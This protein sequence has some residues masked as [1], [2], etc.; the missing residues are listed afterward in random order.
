MRVACPAAGISC[1]ALL[2]APAP[3]RADDAGSVHK[4]L[5]PGSPLAVTVV[6]E[7][8]KVE[9][10]VSA[11][12][13]EVTIERRAHTVE[14]WETTYLVPFFH[15]TE[16]WETAC[17]APCVVHLDSNATYRVGGSGVATSRSFTLPKVGAS[18]PLTLHVQAR[19]A[20]LA[21]AGTVLTTAGAVVTMVG[22]VST[23]Y[24]P[25][26][27]STQAE[28]EVRKASVVILISGGV[29]LAVGIPLLL[30]GKSKVTTDGERRVARAL[31]GS[32]TF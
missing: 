23:L 11:D 21:T 8:R 7:D 12:S 31:G 17:A 13:P 6:P 15:S 30:T 14:G 32:F 29:L 10:A 18:G 28:A 5:S 24:S 2:L 4:P 19:S 3:A 20:L 16:Q 25:S 26:I 27:T 1:L 9:V 22:L